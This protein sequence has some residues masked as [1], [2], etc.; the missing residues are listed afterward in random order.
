MEDVRI[1]FAV[2]CGDHKVGEV[3]RLIAD[4][5]DSHV[6]DLV[7]DRGLLHGAKLV[8]LEDIKDVGGDRIQLRL[9]HDQ[10]E[11][12]D[13]FVD[14]RF[15]QPDDNWSA[16]PGFD[17]TEFLLDVDVSTGAIGGYGAAGRVGP[18]PPEP[19]DPRPNLLR[20]FLNEGTS[21]RSASGEKVGE[22]AQ[23][24]FNPEDGRL[25]GLTM[26]RGLFG[27]EHVE[28]PL[29]WIEGFDGEGIIL[30]VNQERVEELTPK[31]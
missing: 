28:I 9:T 14:E 19:A 5:R 18:Y 7:V 11:K 27:H 3:A 24:S 12:A 8:P 26:K 2:Y 4:T 10:F 15:K 23:I 29:D 20:P 22:V 16:P 25:D 1:G 21:V 13:G 31:S 17:R 30:R 6:T